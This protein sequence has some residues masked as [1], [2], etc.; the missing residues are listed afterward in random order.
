MLRTH[1]GTA[2]TGGI[3]KYPLRPSPTEGVL[4]GVGQITGSYAIKWDRLGLSTGEQR[5]WPDV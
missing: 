3:G 2:L 1:G 5:A 4:P